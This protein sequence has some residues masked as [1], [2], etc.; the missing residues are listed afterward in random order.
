M[1]HVITVR[2][3]RKKG[4][5]PLT[6]KQIGIL[7]SCQIGSV[8]TAK[9]LAAAGMKDSAKCELC[10]KEDEDDIHMLWDCASTHEARKKHWAEKPPG[11][12]D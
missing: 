3:M 7:N 6:A 9:L 2:R 12:Q 1:D 8:R 10:G 5:N 4:K 11:W